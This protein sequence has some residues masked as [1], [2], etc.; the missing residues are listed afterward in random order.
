MKPSVLYRVASALLLLFALGHTLGFRKT[1]PQWGVDTL[2][3]SMRSIHFNVQA[4]NR[5]YWDFYCRVRAFC[6]GVPFIRGGISVA[7][8]RSSSRDFVVYAR[9]CVGARRLL[10]R[11][12]AFELHILLHRT[13]RSF[14][15]DYGVLGNGGMALR[16]TK[17]IWRQRVRRSLRPSFGFGMTRYCRYR[18][19]SNLATTARLTTHGFST[20][21]D[22]E[23]ENG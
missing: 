23:R 4:F 10:Y 8:Q 13:H 2:I 9:Q 15:R 16:E 22:D 19:W 18:G 21:P 7:T 11:R 3:G 1:D 20:F 14:N 5:S 6:L 17:L 12:H